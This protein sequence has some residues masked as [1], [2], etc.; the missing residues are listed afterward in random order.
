MSTHEH[1]G[2]F[3]MEE[4]TQAGENKVGGSSVT[5]TKNDIIIGGGI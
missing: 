5:E 3:R 4:P 1:V 2:F